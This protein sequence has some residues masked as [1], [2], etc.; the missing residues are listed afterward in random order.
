[1][2]RTEPPTNP[3]DPGNKVCQIQS[4][5]H[6]AEPAEKR[7]ESK[8]PATRRVKLFLK[9]RLSPQFKRSLKRKVDEIVVG[10]RQMTGQK[11][12]PGDLPAQPAVEHLK[13]GDRVRVRT[14][15]EIQATLNIWKERNG[16]AFMEDMAQYCGTT[17]RV[18]KPVRR[19]I[20]ERDYTEKKARGVVLLEGVICQGCDRACF[21][22]WR[23][24]WLEKID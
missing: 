10:A 21:Y 15:E 16:C 1:M 14:K 23:E 11:D 18:F 13:A 9:R 24:E 6:I 19:F 8:L 3:N 4:V 20:D 7:D 22:F 5:P 12:T 2:A 17:Q